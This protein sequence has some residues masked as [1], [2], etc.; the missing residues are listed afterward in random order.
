MSWGHVVAIESYPQTLVAWGEVML[1]YGYLR[2]G[3]ETR[4]HMIRY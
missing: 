4:V 2:V 3:T 1:H